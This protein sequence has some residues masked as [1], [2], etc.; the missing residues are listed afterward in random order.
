M[1]EIKLMK[2]FLASV[3]MGNKIIK[4]IESKTF[5][6]EI[7]KLWVDI[8]NS[9]AVHENNIIEVMEKLGVDT[10]VDLS[11]MQKM[12]IC[13]QKMKLKGND[14]VEL[15]FFGI[16]DLEMGMVGTLKFIHVNEFVNGDF[17]SEAISI[18]DE[19]ERSFNRVIKKAKEYLN[20]DY[21]R[22]KKNDN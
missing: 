1:N 3:K 14:D 17:I 20:L 16:E 5:S 6:L 18:Y 9:F 4:N 12:A 19:Y 2:R 22:A 11:M 13:M 8:L 21:R 10:E 7:R 15:L